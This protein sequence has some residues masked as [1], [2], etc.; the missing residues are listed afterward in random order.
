MSSNAHNIARSFEAPIQFIAGSLGGILVD[1]H[2]DYCAAAGIR[3]QTARIRAA[4]LAR[5]QAVARDA[6]ARELDA[7][8]RDALM[9]R[10]I[11]RRA[12]ATA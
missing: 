7:Q 3:A 1:Q 6:A 2:L 10:A 9:R 4:R 12:H 5:E 11:A 8:C